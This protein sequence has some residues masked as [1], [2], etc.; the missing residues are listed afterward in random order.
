MTKQFEYIKNQLAWMKSKVELDNQLGLYDINK[1]G[2]NIFMHI[3]NDIYGWDLKNANLIKENFPAI[4]LVDDINKIV[5]QVTSTTIPKKLRSTIK[6]YKN[7]QQYANYQ[8]KIFYIKEKP[9][10]NRVTKEEFEKDGITNNDILGIDDILNIIQENPKKCQIL[11]KTMQQRFD[12]ISFKFNIESYFEQFE[13]HLQKISSNKFQ[14]YE[15]Y[16]KQFVESDNKLLEI[17]SVGGN[18]KSH[19]LRYL[20]LIETE[21]IALI[22]T[23]QIN[24][25]EDLK[26][27]DK[28]KKYLFILDDID[29]FLDQPLLLNLLSYTLSTHNTKL[30]LSYRTPS[31]SAIESKYRK[32]THIKKQELEII[33]SE[34]EIQE[35]IL[36]LL[37]DLEQ[38]KVI[39]LTHIF[40][41]NPYLITQAVNGNIDTIKDFSKKI[42]DDTKLALKDFDLSEKEISD[43][44][45]NLSLLTP[46]SKNHL[47]EKYKG[48]ISQLIASGILRELASKYRFN[49]DMVGDLYLANYIDENNDN[50]QKIVEVNL[51]NF[52]DTVFTNLSYALVYNKSD[53]LQ[54][55]IK[56]TIKKW[57]ENS[58]Y[59]NEYLSLINKIVYFAP[60]ESFIYLEKATKYLTPKQTNNLSKSG[61]QEV[62]TTVSVNTD[63]Y[64]SDNDAINLESIE[65]IITKLIYALKNNIPTDE[66]K[67]N[68][69][70]SYLS[71]ER[72]LNLPKPYYDNQTLDSIFEK[73]VSPLNTQ[74]YDVVLETFTLLER[75]IKEKPINDRKILLLQTILKSILGALFEKNSFEGST[76]VLSQI[77]LNLKHQ[78]VLNI[79]NQAKDIVFKML[80]SNN[81]N[82]MLRA[83]DVVSNVGTYKLKDLDNEY[84]KF[85]SEIKSEFLVH[86]K[87]G[88]LDDNKFNIKEKLENLLFQILKFSTY[89]PLK[90]KALQV[91]KKI[92]REDEY[93]F[94]LLIKGIDFLIVDFNKFK[95]Q[96]ESNSENK[97][98]WFDSQTQRRYYNK[99]TDDEE[100]I[101]KKL[102]SKYQDVDEFV[103]LMNQLDMSNWNA[104]QTLLVLLNQWYKYN[105][106][107]FESFNDT[108][109]VHLNNQIVKNVIKEL[110]LLKSL[111]EISLDDISNNISNDDLKVYIDVIF[112]N[113]DESNLNILEK[114][115]EVV[116]E[117]H[118][119]EIRMFI[120][121]IS[122]KLYF[123]LAD[124]H[125]LYHKFEQVILKFLQWQLKYK[126]SIESYLTY[127]ILSDIA[128]TNKITI[129]QEIIEVLEKTIK[130]DE[131]KTDEFELKPIYG[132]LDFGLNECINILYSKLTS[133]KEN[134]NP[135][136]VFIHYY[137]SDNISEVILLKSFLNSYKD[138]EILINKVWNLCSNPVSFK[139]ADGKNHK[140][141]VN[142]DYFFKYTVSP[143]YI[144]KIFNLF[145][146]NNDIEKIQF[147]Y[148]IVPVSCKYIN[149]IVKNLNLLEDFVSENDLMNYIREVGKVKMYSSPSMQ[150]SP[151][152]LKE[153]KLF[154][155]LKNNINSLSLQLKINEELKYI[156]IRKK[157]EIE[158][159][160]ARLLDK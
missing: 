96:Y 94:Y 157:Q 47:D 1:L 103:I 4:D 133:L 112:K 10:F 68:H 150:N 129:N 81:E 16:F 60:M 6:S 43:L 8:L 76:F 145:Y 82:I 97:D 102:T 109:F 44:L 143:K 89:K 24:I 30:M 61:L 104:Y 45:F 25:E 116:G 29:R 152:L 108:H 26:K 138:F 120:S 58:E 83:L 42:L 57:I 141:Y 51:K 110:L 147:F 78:D 87:V 142:L 126:F 74:N 155:E 101:I 32:Y 85:Y 46:I 37:P 35:L 154:N 127:H 100:N 91:L 132:I 122:Q 92:N 71:S 49:P 17:Y 19:L 118:P 114:I 99:F 128:K 131:I 56:Q 53:S 134:R 90:E 77:P 139:E 151:T 86:I 67:I 28:G 113:F 7:L 119:D 107:V 55:Y 31:K 38:H 36:L 75:W 93:L 22:F 148:R 111:L 33:W 41:N 5:I 160:I 21:Y 3:L 106:K 98:F 88:I 84:I 50:F 149:V 2:E 23:K 13:P 48:I 66:L 115:V 65:P 124:N 153:E 39:R 95:T 20:A 9:N 159:D 80:D 12:A 63:H 59:K 117:K 54:N 137:D 158:E 135:K 146:E 121:I 144:N 130:D 34:N 140:A 79:I 64:N 69:I 18:G 11:Y 125:Y 156:K 14:K 72:I 105:R 40:N 73:I 62:I 52:S 27:L 123:T 15:K 136:Y 70:I